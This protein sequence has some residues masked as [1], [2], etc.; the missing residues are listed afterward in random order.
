MKNMCFLV[1]F[2]ALFVGCVS[3]DIKS[4]LTK[5]NAYT[6]DDIAAKNKRCLY[7]KNVALTNISSANII[8]NK[9]ILNQKSREQIEILNDGLFVDTPKNMLRI[10]LQKMAINM[11]INLENDSRAEKFLSINLLFLG[12]NGGV[13]TVQLAYKISDLSQHKIG[14]I[15]KNGTDFQ[16]LDNNI[17]SLQNITKSALE[18]LMNLLK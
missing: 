9:N 16:S 1:A 18:D 11:C 14:I 3:I 13:P 17:S 12:F 8:D 7:T 4:K 5:I 6:I 10:A 2:S 15:T